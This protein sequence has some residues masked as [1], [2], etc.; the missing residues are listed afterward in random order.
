MT[1]GSIYQKL[2]KFQRI[3][4]MSHY[5]SWCIKLAYATDNFSYHFSNCRL[6]Q[7]LILLSGS[8]LMH[9]IAPGFYHKSVWIGGFKVLYVEREGRPMEST[10][11]R[12]ENA[13]ILQIDQLLQLLKCQL[14]VWNHHSLCKCYKNYSVGWFSTQMKNYGLYT[15]TW[16][17]V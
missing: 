8:S 6:Y 16:E 7:S 13:S 14:V 17:D 10:V 3:L 1:Q 12:D 4:L 5:L 11:V 9:F 15:E 2:R